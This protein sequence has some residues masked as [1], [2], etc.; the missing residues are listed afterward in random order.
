MINKKKFAILVVTLCSFYFFP[1]V[2]DRFIDQHR[3]V[4][5]ILSDYQSLFSNSLPSNIDPRI[6]NSG[7]GILP[8]PARI[9]IRLLR[10]SNAEFYRYSKAI[11][12][13]DLIKQRLVEGAYP[14]RF[15]ETAHHLL[16]FN[17]ESLPEGCFSLTN[18]KGINLA[19]CP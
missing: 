3:F 14:L 9:M 13:N 10:S 15:S 2:L 6:A 11:G 4:W 19:Y 12:R 7:E 8:E 1:I 16:Y 5:K 18:E 17:W